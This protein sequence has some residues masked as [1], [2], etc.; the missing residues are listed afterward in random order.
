M[1]DNVETFLAHYG[2]EGM[3]WGVRK[4]DSSKP[5]KSKYTKKELAERKR[6][7]QAQQRR[8]VISDQELDR[9]VKR[10]ETEKKLKDLTDKDLNPG[11]TV[12][13]TLLTT[14]GTAVAA[15]A[16]AGALKYGVKAALT[17]SFS[18]KDAAAYIIPKPKK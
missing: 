9:L 3:R 10:L 13:A 11:R 2:V 6:R 16:V 8:R 12:V 7:K 18:L 1:A 14:A 5:R 4:P 15:V 17:R